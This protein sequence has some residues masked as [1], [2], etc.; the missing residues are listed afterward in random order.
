MNFY[1]IF[2]QL[3]RPQ[4]LLAASDERD[5]CPSE[6]GDRSFL[7]SIPNLLVALWRPPE[8]V[9]LKSG[10]Q[11]PAK[12]FDSAAPLSVWKLYPDRPR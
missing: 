10:N 3:G 9:F 5:S 12:F 2:K 1:A 11:Q 6:I 7:D 8:V 4:F